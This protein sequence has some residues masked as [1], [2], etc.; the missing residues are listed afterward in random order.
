M[1]G[2]SDPPQFLTSLLTMKMMVVIDND[3]E[4]LIVS[5]SRM[6]MNIAMNTKTET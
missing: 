6:M 5:V 4:L 1:N 2:E 3:Q